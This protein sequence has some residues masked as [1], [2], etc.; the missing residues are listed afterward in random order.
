[1]LQLLCNTLAMGINFQP[2][3]KEKQCILAAAAITV[4]G[5]VQ[6]SYGMRRFAN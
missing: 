3:N 4:C 6:K 1:M 5:L 2:F